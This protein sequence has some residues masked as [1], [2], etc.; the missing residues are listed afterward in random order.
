MLVKL[1]Y[2]NASPRGEV[3]A[4]TQAADM[5][6]SH[7]GEAVDV[8]T[9]DLFTAALPD[10][11]PVLAAAKQ[12]AGWGGDLS[13]EQAAEWLAVTAL[14]EQFL[15]VDH[16]LFAVPMWNFS[17]P[18]KLK[19]YIDLITHPNLTFGRGDDGNMAGLGSGGATVIFSRGGDYSPKDGQPDPFDFQS[20][21]F[22]A[23]LGLVGLGPVEEVLVQ[24]TM[25]GPEVLKAALESVRGQLEAAA[26]A[27]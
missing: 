11:T 23:W 18:Y 6:L 8:T 15:A 22:K 17:I 5:F 26:G 1:L 25:S 19:Q 9:L 14:V 10:Y 16:Y 3:S 7:L 12:A 13:E 20:P 27:V 21:Y 24:R 2:I 4:S